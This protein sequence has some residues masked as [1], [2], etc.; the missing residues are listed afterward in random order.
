VMHSM[1]DC[2]WR[3]KMGGIPYWS[4]NGP[5][6]KLKPDF[7]FLFQLD[8]LIPFEGEAPQPDDFGGTVVFT[9][10]SGTGK[11]LRIARQESHEPHPS[12]KR[13][14]APWSA[15]VDRKG[16]FE[17]EITNLGTDGTAYVFINR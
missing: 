12:K 4:G 6:Q 1:F 17:V 7:E 8:N 15:G 9:E 3:T 14:N 16:R 5:L 10:Y 11:N 2:R 13:L